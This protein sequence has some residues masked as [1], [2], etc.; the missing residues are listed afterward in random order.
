MAVVEVSADY[1]GR[2][3]T[4]QTG[5]LAKQAE[6]MRSELALAIRGAPADQLAKYKQEFGAG[7]T[8]LDQSFKDAETIAGISLDSTKLKNDL[9][10]NAIRTGFLEN[11]TQTSEKMGYIFREEEVYLF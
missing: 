10:A 1:G 8:P 4:L 7:N 9:R 11:P 5:K 3:L 2:K 6:N